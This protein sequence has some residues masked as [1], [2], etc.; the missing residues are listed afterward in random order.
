MKTT[1]LVVLICLFITAE[2]IRAERSKSI[3]VT[4]TEG[5]N[6]STCADDAVQDQK[7]LQDH[8]AHS[9]ALNKPHSFPRDPKSTLEK[10]SFSDVVKKEAKMRFC[11]LKDAK[12]NKDYV[13]ET[14]ANL[15]AAEL[16]V[17][18]QN[19]VRRHDLE[20]QFAQEDS[21]NKR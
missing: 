21:A 4:G 10:M 17:R 20:A 19:F 2:G 1:A 6:A 5:F 9:S 3:F 8:I 18:L 7:L 12:N 16:S 14:E 13:Y 11:A 15:Y